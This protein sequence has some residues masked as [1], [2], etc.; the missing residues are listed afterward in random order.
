M[1]FGM[2][3]QTSNS[4]TFAQNSPGETSGFLLTILKKCSTMQG[5]YPPIE[6]EK[7]Q[8]SLMS[9]SCEW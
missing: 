4:L 3:Y 2:Q 6:L 7:P 8:A 5:Q 9:L 1:G